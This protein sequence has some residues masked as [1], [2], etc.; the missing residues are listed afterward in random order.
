MKFLSTL[1]LLVS[2]AAAAPQS[3]D[4]LPLAGDV[5]KE[6]GKDAQPGLEQLQG[7]L[8]TDTIGD[9]DGTAGPKDVLSSLLGG[10]GLGGLGR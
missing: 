6:V 4:S 7:Q 10:I 1:A 5:I 3:L 2:A 8:D 9:S